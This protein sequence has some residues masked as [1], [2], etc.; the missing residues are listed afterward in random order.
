V[1]GPAEGELQAI[2]KGLEPGEKV[3]LEGLDRL[4]E[5]RNVTMVTDEPAGE[6]KAPPAKKAGG[7]STKT[8]KSKGT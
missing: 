5:G 3:I 7:D 4:R 8:R 1:L 6:K 2:A